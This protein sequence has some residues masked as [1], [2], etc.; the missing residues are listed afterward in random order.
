MI[1]FAELRTRCDGVFFGIELASLRAVCAIHTRRVLIKC[2]GGDGYFARGSANWVG[3]VVDGPTTATGQRR[4][5]ECN[6]I[7]STT[8]NSTN[9]DP[10]KAALA[11]IESLKPEEKLVYTKIA[12]RFGVNA[13]TLA[14]R[15]KGS[16][17]SRAIASQNRRALHP[18]EEQQLLRY[19]KKLSS[20]GLPP[21]R[22]MIQRFASQIAQ[23][24]LGVH[25]VDRYIHRYEAHL[26]SR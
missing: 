7:N 17:T 8:R 14:R 12:N 19:I 9:M 16:S 26:I 5:R 6:T 10:I 20:Q 13:V 1:W 2:I 11:A 15:H 4:I 22:A 18:H 25:W 23:Q 21:S 3:T 24:E